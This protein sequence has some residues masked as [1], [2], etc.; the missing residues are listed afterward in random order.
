MKLKVWHVGLAVLALAV[1]APWPGD[2][3]SDAAAVGALR[4]AN[5]W[6][7]TYAVQIQRSYAADVR[8]RQ[9]ETAVGFWQ[10]SAAAAARTDDSL[11]GELAAARTPAD[12]LR[13]CLALN[14]AC[15][16]K[17]DAWHAAADS[18]RV[19][20][21]TMTADRDRLKGTATAAVPVIDST[22]HVLEAKRCRILFLPCP[23]RRQAVAL[24][25]VAAE[26]IRLL[27]RGLT[28]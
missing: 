15:E 13:I 9:L 28:R 10:D 19:G 20:L 25:A 3:A 8:I 11:T 7:H 4:L 27:L 2:H 17:A 22:T 24:G 12:S 23:T 5:R 14:R 16:A 6:R 26:G 21:D 18:L 1:L